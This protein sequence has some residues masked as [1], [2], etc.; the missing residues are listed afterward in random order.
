M[1]NNTVAAERPTVAVKA[2]DAHRLSLRIWL[3]IALTA[4]ALDAALS[5]LSIEVLGIAAEG[6]PLLLALDK[7]I[8]FLL[9]MHIRFA[10]GAVLLLVIYRLALKMGA[11][12]LAAHGLHF[13]SF[14]LVA[15]VGYHAI[16]LAA[17]LLLP[18]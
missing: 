1:A 4:T 9:T 2:D 17:G 5:Y 10:V 3:A 15:L 12:S 13:V 6:N 7:E 11:R 14:I 18:V 16:I 8:G